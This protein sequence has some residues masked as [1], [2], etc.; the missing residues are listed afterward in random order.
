MLLLSISQI[1][2]QHSIPRIIF[3]VSRTLAATVAERWLVEDYAVKSRSGIRLK[4]EIEAQLHGAL[5]VPWHYI[6]R[7]EKG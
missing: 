3:N 6:D 2:C 4:H 7:A 5:T 1:G